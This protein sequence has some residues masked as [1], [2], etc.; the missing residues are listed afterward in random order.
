M[1]R[2]RRR[3]RPTPWLV[4]LAALALGP[5]GCAMESHQTLQPPQVTSAGTAYQSPK[6]TLVVGKF[7]NRSSY[8]R[9]LFSDGVDRLGGQAKGI[10]VTHLQQ[11][12]ALHRDRADNLEEIPC[13]AFDQ[14]LRIGYFAC[15]CH[16]SLP[17]R[18]ADQILTP[19]SLR[20][21]TTTTARPSRRSRQKRRNG[22]TRRSSAWTRTIGR[23]TW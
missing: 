23:D 15:H 20:P 3:A 18:P 4:A 11:T 6:S 7:D 22:P 13:K 1:I 17:P 10:L 5:A 8:L 16:S 14:A 19:C 21:S 12:G 9:G 2:S